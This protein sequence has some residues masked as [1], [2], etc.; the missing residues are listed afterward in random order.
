MSK[1]T[2]LAIQ[3]VMLDALE[4]AARNAMEYSAVHIRKMPEYY[5]NVHIGQALS[6]F[7]PNIGYRLE[8]PVIHVLD[9][10]K[11]SLPTSPDDLRVAGKLDLVITSRKTGNLRHVVEVKRS[12]LSIQLIKEAKRIKALAI[13]GISENRLQTGYIAAVST[14]TKGN[15]ALS[16][17]DLLE[18]RLVGLEEEFG[19]EFTID[20]LHKTMSEGEY[21]YP[22]NKALVVVVFRISRK[23][24]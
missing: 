14:L 1:A 22:K 18:S 6:E 7:F 16:E 24:W 4:H 2:T 12:L 23:N 5:L 21:G 11:V 9:K 3:R 10:L 17:S 19:N 15:G 20:Y 8:M 13:E